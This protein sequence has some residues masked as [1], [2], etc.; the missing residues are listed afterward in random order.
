MCPSE[1]V[2]LGVSHCEC[3]LVR[4]AQANG[5]AI[6]EDL[7]KRLAAVLHAA[8]GEKAIAAVHS[9]AD[10]TSAPKTD[11]HPPAVSRTLL[12]ARQAA[13]RALP[14]ANPKKESQSSRQQAPRLAV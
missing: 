12:T 8:F 5:L 7:G 10:S 2:R 3:P 9:P 4:H 6:T 11:S 13:V 1:K 14:I